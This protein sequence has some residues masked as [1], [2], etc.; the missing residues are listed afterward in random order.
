MKYEIRIMY[1]YDGVYQSQHHSWQQDG[2]QA[3]DIVAELNAQG[4]NAFI[5]Y[6]R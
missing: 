2:E 5:N 3:E 6:I 1:G 4:Y